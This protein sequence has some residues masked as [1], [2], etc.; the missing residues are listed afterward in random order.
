[1]QRREY[2]TGLASA[3][4]IVTVT[5]TG[6]AI[7]DNT[8]RGPPENTPGQGPPE[9][10]PP[11]QGDSVFELADQIDNVRCGV[12]GL[13]NRGSGMV[14]H[15]DSMYPERGEI[16]AICDL[17][18]EAVDDTMDWFDENS[19]QDPDTYYGSENAYQDL[20]E[21]DDIDVVFIHTH[22]QK[23][24]EI[25]VYAME[26]GSHAG[27]EVPAAITIEECW[28]LV[29]TAE[30][31][32]QQCIML[33]NVNYFQEE[34]WLLNMAQQGVFGDQLSYA[35]GGYIH[36]LIGNYFFNAYWNNWRARYHYNRKG[37]LYPTH[38]LGPIAHYMDILRGDRMEYIVAHDSPE[39]R[40]TQAAA[41]LPDDHEFAGATD[42]ANGDMATS[43]IATNEGKQI[44]LQ[45]DVKT[46]RPYNRH[47]ELAGNKAF[48][49]GYPSELTINGEF[50][51]QESG[52]DGYD[53]YADEYE[54]PLWEVAGDLA[55]EHG[56]H[57]GG[58]WLMVYR[59]FD[60]FND[61]R[62]Q[63]INVY[64]AATWS[65]VIPLSE[66]SVEH[67]S[68]PVMFPNFTRGG[69]KKERDLQTMQFETIEEP[70]V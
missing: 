26:Q 34:M 14:S 55:E 5:P 52:D 33:E 49:T 23:H 51:G 16:K 27:V 58:D 13:G 56:G 64:E 29:D 40:M 9:N 46:T 62:P 70:G 12:I 19:E 7:Q 63:D 3:A 31:T 4:G 67:G 59:L 6:K 44:T 65:S 22:P 21:R 10:T 50:T 37:D 57:G 66:I 47:N 60:A 42:W 61:G 43:I 24:A 25:A 68:A 17:R 20:C 2:M 32:Q 41:E 35:K 45:H 30:K 11:R 8:G 15:Y 28:D 1:M 54:H 36:H 18:K 48:H 38:G 53:Q 39:T 69:W